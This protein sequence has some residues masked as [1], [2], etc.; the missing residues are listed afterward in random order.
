[1][2]PRVVAAHCCWISEPDIAIIKKYDVGVAYC[3]SC[4]AKMADGLPPVSRLVHDHVSVAI[5]IDAT[6][7]NNSADLLREAKIGTLL[8]KVAPPLDP[9]LLPAEKALEMITVDAARALGLQSEV[10][11]LEVGKKA[12]LIALRI[13]RPQYVPLLDG[14]RYTIINH[15]IYAGSGADVSEV[16]VNGRRVI[17]NYELVTVD[18]QEVVASAQRIFVE[19]MQQSGINSEINQMRWTDDPDQRAMASA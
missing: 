12:D 16:I 14:P 10:G 11:S 1:D 13:D 8:Q 18:E 7:V 17:E 3:P 4:E 5:S 19:F 9:E 6:C 15:L 2:A